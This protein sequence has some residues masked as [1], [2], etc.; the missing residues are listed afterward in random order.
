MYIKHCNKTERQPLEYCHSHPLSARPSRVQSQI[1]LWR[2]QRE[3]EGGQSLSR[4]PA[5]CVYSHRVKRILCHSSAVGD[6]G[7]AYNGGVHTHCTETWTVPQRTHF[8]VSRAEGGGMDGEQ[9]TTLT[10]EAT[11]A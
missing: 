1:T 11:G 2:L 6:K 8:R 5:P 7:R 10:S 9:E 3:L 4:A